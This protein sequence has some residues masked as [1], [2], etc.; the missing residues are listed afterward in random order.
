M[1]ARTIDMHGH[2]FPRFSRDAA[3]RIGA[4]WPWLR[5]DGDG[6]GTVMIEGDAFRPVR[7]PLWDVPARIAELD[8][9]G[10]DLQILSAT[11]V[12]FGYVKPAEQAAEA[13]E[14]FN[15][16]AL[17][18]CA[19][20]PERL[21]TLCQVPL[22]D[23]DRACREVERAMA[24][25]HIGVQI[26]NHIGE[27]EIDDD[28]VIRFLN[29]CAEI[30]APVMVHPWDM[31]APERMQGYMLPWLVGMPAETQLSI[32]RL[33]LSGAFERL[34]RD[35]RIVFAHG[36]GSFPYLLGRI[37]NG[38]R[39]HPRV[40]PDCPHPPS[41]Y[42]DRFHVDCAVFSDAALALVVDVMGPDRVLYGS[43]YPFPLAEQE[44][45]LGVRNHPDLSPETKAA[46]LSS[47]TEAFFDI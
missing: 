7:R 32:T 21:R 22:Q 30:G 4:S 34:L 14:R 20:A 17:E 13:A 46:I 31:M 3:D 11:P 26:G 8:A 16:A 29:H 15:D 18:M 43:D 47:N 37:E 41:H 10:I 36:G 12:M 2:F 5:E 6:L 33:I 24:A 44:M 42:L 35:L 19:A 28:E 27:R 45:T 9:Q 1:S 38:W 39:H 25:G 40:S 23:T